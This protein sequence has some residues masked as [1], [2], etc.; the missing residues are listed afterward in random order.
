MF[1][2]IWDHVLKDVDFC[3]KGCGF[4]S[5]KIRD[6]FSEGS[7][8]CVWKDPELRLTGSSL[9][10]KRIWD[11]SLEG[12]GI[13][14]ERIRDRGSKDRE[15]CWKGPGFLF[16]RIRAG[17]SLEPR[18]PPGIL[19]AG[20][21]CAGSG[22][23]EAPSIT[24]PAAGAAAPPSHLSTGNRQFLTSQKSWDRCP[25]KSNPAGFVLRRERN[26]TAQIPLCP[27]LGI[28]RFSTLDDPFQ[29]YSQPFSSHIPNPF[30]APAPTFP[31]AWK[32]SQKKG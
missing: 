11:S 3:F 16:E 4:V 12:S 24:A 25:G 23:L 2:R 10:F 17:S 14:L 1:K 20:M 7:R 31:P 29:P 9:T 27:G 5:E 15:L 19:G 32:S 26:E 21:I 13:V 6:C 22:P 8:I 18:I 30:P 28:S